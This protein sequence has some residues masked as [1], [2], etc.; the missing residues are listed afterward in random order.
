MPQNLDGDIRDGDVVEF[1]SLMIKSLGW[2][3]L[4]NKFFK[5]YAIYKNVFY[6]TKCG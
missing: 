5:K 6:H 2:D 4:T 3:G 1:I